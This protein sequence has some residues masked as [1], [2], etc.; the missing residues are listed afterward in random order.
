MQKESDKVEESVSHR[1]TYF[2]KLPL[3]IMVINCKELYLQWPEMLV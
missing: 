2:S 1:S 3:T